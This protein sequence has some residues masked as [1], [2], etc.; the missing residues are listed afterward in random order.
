MNTFDFINSRD[1]R[2]H[3]E[4]IDYKFTPIEAAWLVWQCD[5][6]SLHEKINRSNEIID[7]M[8]N[9]D[10]SEEHRI[11]LYK[12]IHSFLK[13]FIKCEEKKI[14]EFKD[15][16]DGIY[17][18]EYKEN[19]FEFP[20]TYKDCIYTSYSS[21]IKAIKEI[22]STSEDANIKFY[23]DKLGIGNEDSTKY[24]ILNSNFEILKI[25]G[26]NLTDEENKNIQNFVKLKLDFPIPFKKGDI[27][28][29]YNCKFYPNNTPF[30]FS[31]I[32]NPKEYE[33][34][35]WVPRQVSRM[36]TKGY[37]QSS[38]N[39]S[40]FTDIKYCYMDL[41]YYRGEFSGKR[42]ILKGLSNFIKGE[43]DIGL[44]SRAYSTILN[45]EYAKEIKPK[46][47]TEK[48]MELAGIIK[49]S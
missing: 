20:I 11:T 17:R 9:C 45:E 48:G 39:G 5:T 13:W 43:I 12:D 16:T 7:T 4:D 27:V 49:D 21:C 2:K 3:L 6:L 25:F 47:Y 37:F 15:N 35:L 28:Q 32:P 19:G 24:A 29:Y 46:S 14:L 34:E 10:F 38:S 36:L 44:Y 26:E 41:E 22:I 33:N 31:D 42:R 18:I 8:P 40:I 23:V 1:I 30:V